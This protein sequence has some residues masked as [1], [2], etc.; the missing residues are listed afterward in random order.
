MTNKA[1][2]PA[3]AAPAQEAAAASGG[4]RAGT[5]I[6][7]PLGQVP[8]E[9]LTVGD[10]VLTPAGKVRR[11]VGIG[12][13]GPGQPPVRVAAGALADGLPRRDLVLAPGQAVL[14][15]DGDSV[16]AVPALLLVNGASITEAAGEAADIQVELKQ[17]DGLLAEGQPVEYP[18]AVPGGGAAIAAPLVRIRRRIDARAGVV[19]GE[20]AGILGRVAA[21]R[22]SGWAHDRGNPGRP[23][24]L[25]VAVNGDVVGAVLAD[26]PRADLEA[27]TGSPARGYI[28]A[29]PA[30][31]A[32]DRRHL[33]SVRRAQD[34]AELP[35]SPALLDQ[36]PS[37]A[38]LLAGL[39]A[40][41]AAAATDLAM[42]LTAQIDRL[43]A[44]RR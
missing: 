23:V 24:L 33:I 3:R 1:I 41:D 37:A 21:D 27:V 6:A 36:A 38:A 11:V 34:G 5:R 9:A 29:L 10:A 4:L 2:G 35:G 17:P 28:F 20:L 22:L 30:P 12:R 7:T 32:G 31:L 16:V 8:V 43:R 26:H 42:F 25:E 40:D 15:P 14:L 13:R 18:G 44:A 19:P 39:R